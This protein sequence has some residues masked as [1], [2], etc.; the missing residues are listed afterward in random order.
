MSFFPA[1]PPQ[2]PCATCKA[3]FAP[4][5]WRDV[6]NAGTMLD[7]RLE[8]CMCELVK[9]AQSAIAEVHMP[10]ALTLAQQ[11]APVHLGLIWQTMGYFLGTNPDSLLYAAMHR[12]HS[13]EGPGCE[14]RWTADHQARCTC[15]SCTARADQHASAV[16]LDNLIGM[17]A[18]CV[19]GC[20]CCGHTIRS[21]HGS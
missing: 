11:A 2:P 15:P 14:V 17:C 9:A 6:L 5:L 20:M 18:H 7:H 16:K 3:Q 19:M 21:T 13:Q 12:T 4:D 10:D 1:H 8:R